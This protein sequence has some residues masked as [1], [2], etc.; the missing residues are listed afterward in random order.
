MLCLSPRAWPGRLYVPLGFAGCPLTLPGSL[1]GLRPSRSSCSLSE[2]LRCLGCHAPTLLSL[3]GVL[4][5]SGNVGPSMAKV[6][7]PPPPGP[8]LRE[9]FG[10]VVTP[11]DR[12]PPG[13]TPVTA[14]GLLSSTVWPSVHFGLRP[15]PPWAPGTVGSVPRVEEHTLSPFHDPGLRGSPASLPGVSSQIGLSR[16][17]VWGRPGLPG[18]TWGVLG[19]SLLP[20]E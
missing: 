5:F 17:Q 14:E 16:H 6:A 2:A 12:C 19:S 11:P 8:G 10:A 1:P 9:A 7:G 13:L 18:D 15:D 3:V 4:C 20:N